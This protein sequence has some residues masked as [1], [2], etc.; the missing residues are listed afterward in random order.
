MPDNRPSLTSLIE[1][2]ERVRTQ[3]ENLLERR[4]AAGV[5]ELSGP[6]AIKFR[7]MLA[8]LRD[9]DEDIESRR[10]DDERGQIPERF[11]RLGRGSRMNPRAASLLSPVTFSDEQLREAHD[12]ARRGEAVSL[13]TRAPGFSSADSLL[14]P[15]LFPIPTFPVHEAR[16]ADHIP[17]Y[18]LDAPSLEYVQV[19][20]VTGSAAI[21][22]EGQPKPEIVA[23]ATKL[24]C[25]ALKLA[26]HGGLSWEN[27]LDY[28]TFSTAVRTELMRQVIDAE[29][30]QL[31]GGDPAAGGFNSLTKTAG[32]LTFTATGF[33]PNSEHFTDL[34]G[35]IAHLRTGPALAVPDLLLLHPNTF[36]SLRTE[37]DQMGRFYVAADPSQTQVE[38]IW[39]VPV[40]QS[41][42]FT[43]GEAVLVDTTKVGRIAVRESITVRIGYSGT[44]F[45]DNVLRTVVE[46]R[47]NFAIERPAAICHV[48]GLPATAPTERTAAKSTAKR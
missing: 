5:S 30:A 25:T 17:G 19:N 32:I 46:C 26:C 10:H 38:E 16:L 40:L 48:T 41:V 28:D 29:N 18:A 7:A 4:K 42:A 21:V 1:S 14:P 47:E 36:A 2:R 31:W 20:A 6:D 24:V 23:P 44:D 22:G 45:T 34:A 3:A 15:E 35:A 9:F 33:G 39:G 12:R 27:V 13:E 11:A 43:A 37:Q 8:D